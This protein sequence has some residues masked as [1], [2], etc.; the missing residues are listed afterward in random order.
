MVR[1]SCF[2]P[3]YGATTKQR[4]VL[5]E[6]KYGP[7][8]RNQG[9]DGGSR[10]PNLHKALLQEHSRTRRAKLL[11]DNLQAELAGDQ[12]TQRS[13]HAWIRNQYMDN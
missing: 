11:E 6:D 4:S 12:N 13:A 1:A 10:Y 9:K 8:S 5:G 7:G 2:S 3:R